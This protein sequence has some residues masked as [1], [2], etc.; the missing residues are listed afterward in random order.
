MVLSVVISIS[1][2]PLPFL[3]ASNRCGT[4]CS[5]GY[6]QRYPAQGNSEQIEL[7]A[8]ARR[9]FEEIGA[10]GEGAP[11]EVEALDR[12]VEAPRE[13]LGIGPVASSAL[14]KATDVER[15]AA[16]IADQVQDMLGLARRMGI[17]PFG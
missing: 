14:S 5:T 12:Q 13:Q 7:L 3:S 6:A 9:D 4:R 17:E 2:I 1:A 10:V 8:F 16:R 11:V 15:A